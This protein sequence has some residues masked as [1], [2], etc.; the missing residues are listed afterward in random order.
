MHASSTF[1]IL[2]IFGSFELYCY[3]L[4]NNDYFVNI[5]ELGIFTFYSKV[6]DESCIA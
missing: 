3:V 6:C 1:M 4:V 5:Y 2:V